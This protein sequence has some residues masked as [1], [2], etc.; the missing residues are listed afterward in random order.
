MGLTQYIYFA[1]LDSETK[2][3]TLSSNLHYV[4]TGKRVRP[5]YTSHSHCLLHHPG[6]SE[7][8]LLGILLPVPRH[9]E[10][11]PEVT[12]DQIPRLPIH[13]DVAWMSISKSQ[14]IP[15]HAHNRIRQDV[16]V[17]SFYPHLRTRAS[18]VEDQG[19]VLASS[20]V[21]NLLKHL[22][23]HHQRQFLVA[24]TELVAE[25]SFE[26]RS[27]VVPLPVLLDQQMKSVTVGSPA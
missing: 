14:D 3:E 9:I 13:H 11:L 15:H 7:G 2:I 21:Q 23:L 8:N 22:Y 16:V 27:D 4:V 24:E 5:M 20:N 19:Q 18:L 17:S 26:G 12:M 25:F 10:T 1:N 6:E